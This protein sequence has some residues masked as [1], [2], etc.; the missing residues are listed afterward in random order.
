MSDLTC[1]VC[2]KNSYIDPQIEIYISPCYH[3]LCSTCI[4]RLFKSFKTQNNCP[5][6]GLLLKRINF[7]V[8]TF[9]DLEIE[10]ECRIRKLLHDNQIIRDYKSFENGDFKNEDEYNDYLESMEDLVFELC[11]LKNEDLMKRINMIKQTHKRVKINDKVELFKP[12]AELK[13]LD[14]KKVIRTKIPNH[15]FKNDYRRNIFILKC[16]EAIYDEN[17]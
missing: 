8:Q 1:P 15:I 6:C 9:E 13:I 10:K 3:K 11:N 14:F 16:S 2:H 5:Q 12:I 7:F 17:I 4:N